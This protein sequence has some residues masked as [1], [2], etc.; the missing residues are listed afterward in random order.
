[1]SA[2][3]IARNIGVSYKTAWFMMHRI[4]EAMKETDAGPLG[5]YGET[6]EAD[7][8]YVGGKMKNRH[9]D[10]RNLRDDR[11]DKRSGSRITEKQPVVALVERG[12]RVRS[13]HVAKVTGD[14]LRAVLVTNA[15]RGSWL[16]TDEH[17][18]Y[19]AVG[20]EFV[21]HGTV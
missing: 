2:H 17:N 13:F 4:R 8:T 11:S 19:A 20:K 21:G 9:A 14:T 5:G 12:G 18:G 6:I 10:K 16:M 7:E 1:T 15:D 3:Q